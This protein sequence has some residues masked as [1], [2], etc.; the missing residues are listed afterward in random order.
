MEDFNSIETVDE[1]WTH[2]LLQSFHRSIFTSFVVF[3]DKLIL[4]FL[5]TRE[6]ESL[7]VI[8][9]VRT[10]IGSQ[11]DDG[12]IELHAITLTVGENPIFK[13]LQQHIK[14]IWVS[15]FNF[16]KEHHGVWMTAHRFG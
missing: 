13:N 16:I 15:F 6:T 9:F 2:R 11:N 10:E 4:G 7:V 12:I 14:D 5:V 3:S 1:L 8:H